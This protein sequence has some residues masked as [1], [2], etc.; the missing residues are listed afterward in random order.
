LDS[1]NEDCDSKHFLPFEVTEKNISRLEGR[2]DDQNI[3]IDVRN[4]DIIGSTIYIRTPITCAGKNGICK[5]CY[6][7]L[8]KTNSEYHIGVVAVL[9]LT[10][11]ITQMLEFGIQCS[12][13]L[14]KL[15]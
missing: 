5:K 9:I 4:K 15:I 8:W 12:D 13:T 10:N 1:S 11:Q 7:D 3:P 2:Y 14:S 6:G